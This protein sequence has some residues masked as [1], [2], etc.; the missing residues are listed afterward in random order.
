ML[1][2]RSSEQSEETL[3]ALNRAHRRTAAASR[4][5]AAVEMPLRLAGLEVGAVLGQLVDVTAGSSRI[6]TNGCIK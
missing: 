5:E 2:R 4:K 1:R 6:G 3:G